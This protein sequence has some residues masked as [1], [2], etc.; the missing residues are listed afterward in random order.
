ML[1]P[2][3]LENCYRASQDLRRFQNAERKMGNNNM[4]EKS[5]CVEG[6]IAAPI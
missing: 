6:S 1:R 4:L 2:G 5:T 3:V